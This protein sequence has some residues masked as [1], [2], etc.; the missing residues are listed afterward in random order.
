MYFENSFFLPEVRDGFYVS[1]RMKRTWAAT[2][3]VYKAVEQVCRAN[4]ISFYAD[5][6]TLLGAVRH[7][8]FIPWD[9]DFDICM[10]REDYMRFIQMADKELPGEYACLSVYRDYKYEQL[11]ARVVNREEFVFGDRY[12][13]EFH[14]FPYNVGIDI[15]PVDYINRDEEA[16]KARCNLARALKYHIDLYEKDEVELTKNR[17]DILVIAKGIGYEIVEGKPVR[18]QLYCMLDRIMSYYGKNEGDMLVTIANAM[19]H[20][21]KPLDAALFEDTISVPF[22]NTEVVV[23]L[24][25]DKI[26]EL[27]F[28]DYMK[29]IRSWDTHSYP[30]YIEIEDA[31]H[32]AGLNHIW[33][34]YTIENAQ[35]SIQYQ[36]EKYVN[37]GEFNETEAY[38]VIFMPYKADHWCWMEPLW[39]SMQESGNINTYVMPIPYYYKSN[40]GRLESFHYEGDLLPEYVPVIAFD[41]YDLEAKRPHKIV[42]QNVYD[43]Y[44]TTI[45]IPPFFYA[46]RI[47]RFTDCIVCVPDFVMDD[48]GPEDE[49]AKYNMDFYCTA[50]G[51]IN[52]SEVYVQ[53][54]SIRE[55]Y[56]EKLTSFAGEETIDLWKHKIRVCPW[57][58]YNE[59]GVGISEDNIPVEWIPKLYDINGNGKKILLYYSSISRIAEYGKRYIDKVRSVFELIESEKDKLT[60]IWLMQR[61]VSLLCGKYEKTKSAINELRDDYSKKENIIIADDDLEDEAIAISDAFY[62]DRGSMMH[63]FER[64]RRPVMIQSI[65]LI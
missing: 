46:E 23:P 37:N 41:Q 56:I 49:R 25:Y 5:Y 9:D 18:Q 63:R 60:V 15:F 6:G 47:K 34:N 20:G 57:E 19:T 39:I 38:D 12:S 58:I 29:C 48:F 55:R 32:G 4:N 14:G 2:L 35:E 3:E 62:G 28:A 44:D 31:V 8:G 13:D 33:P 22:E 24:Y 51:V 43:Q 27:K 1:S 21:S 65:D 59:E 53:S 54:E 16:E 11:L 30:V 26:L 45:S 52:A 17:D 42:I 50:P 10:K 40:T 7:G 61:N 36:M 64:C